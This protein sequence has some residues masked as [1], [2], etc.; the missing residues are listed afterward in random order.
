MI[1]LELYRLFVIVAN[2]GNITKA[3]KILHISQ[4]AI[5]KQIHNLEFELNTTFIPNS[6]YYPSL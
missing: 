4:P 3:S 1:N 6:L 5:T 2:E